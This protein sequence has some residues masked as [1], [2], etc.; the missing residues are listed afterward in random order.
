MPRNLETSQVCA[1]RPA[2]SANKRAF[3]V[4]SA[5]CHGWQCSHQ[6]KGEGTL[7]SVVPLL[8]FLLIHVGNWEVSQ[9]R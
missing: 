8:N 4:R 9:L 1:I 5:G 6:R 3:S 2:Q 7:V